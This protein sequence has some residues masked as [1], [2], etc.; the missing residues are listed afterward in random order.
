MNKKGREE[1]YREQTQDWYAALGRFIIK[2]EDV[3]DKMETAIIMILDHDGLRT[4]ILAHALLADLT[5]YP[6]LQRF[7]SI[8]AELR[9]DDPDDLQILRDVSRRVQELIERRNDVLHR[10]WFIGYASPEQEDFSNVSSWKFKTTSRGTE[11]KP[12]EYTAAD[13]SA[14]AEQA[15][16]L[17]KMIFMMDACLGFSIPFTKNFE[18][19]KDGTLRLPPAKQ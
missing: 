8:V 2:F 4:Q 3:R 14:L 11:F 10:K 16:E 12:L 18:V 13:L 7:W 17:A 1:K 9:K 15:D 6:L 19:E 5:A